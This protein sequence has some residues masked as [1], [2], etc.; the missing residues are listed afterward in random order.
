MK[1]N[2]LNACTGYFCTRTFQG[3]NGEWRGFFQLVKMSSS[4]HTKAATRADT[5]PPPGAEVRAATLITNPLTVV[6]IKGPSV[7][8]RQYSMIRSLK[9]RSKV[10]ECTVEKDF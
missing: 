2:I 3:R 1:Q 10:T 8:G 4:V 5:E 6:V 7:L 9:K